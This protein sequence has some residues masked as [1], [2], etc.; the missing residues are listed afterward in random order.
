MKIRFF[1]DPKTKQPHI[2]NHNVDEDEV[3]DVLEYPGEDR[4]GREGSRITIGQTQ[5]GRYLKVIYVF[6]PEFDSVF[7]ITASE[8]RAKPLSAY[9][10]RKRKRR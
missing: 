7:V 5:S 1:I 6:E 2:H 9:K 3:R 4:H 8:L 10:G